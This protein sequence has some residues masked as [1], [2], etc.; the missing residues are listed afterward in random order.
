MLQITKII[1]IRSLLLLVQSLFSL[2]HKNNSLT[3]Y[4]N[5]GKCTI[6]IYKLL[7]TKNLKLHSSLLP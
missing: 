6:I 2:L 3:L 5:L 4:I 7:N 1:N